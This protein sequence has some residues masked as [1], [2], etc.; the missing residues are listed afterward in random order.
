MRVAGFAN[1]TWN[2]SVPC[3]AINNNRGV[4]V[5]LGQDVV[6]WNMKTNPRGCRTFSAPMRGVMVDQLRNG[7]TFRVILGPKAKPAWQIN[8]LAQAMKTVSLCILKTR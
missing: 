4:D 7:G 3:Y 5:H 8:G 2:V 1:G 6:R